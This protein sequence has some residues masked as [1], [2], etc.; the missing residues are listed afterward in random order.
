[1]IKKITKLLLVA[2]IALNLSLATA[3]IT[4]VSADFCSDLEGEF[5]GFLDCEDQFTSFTDFQGGMEAPDSEGFDAS[6]TK[7]KDARTFAKNIANFALGFLG[8]IAVM[9]I[10][11]SGFLYVVAAGD[12]DKMSK[13]KSGITSAMIG[14]VIILS[15]FAIVN[16]IL[17]APS[18]DSTDITTGSLHGAGS[19][20]QATNEQQIQSYNIAA[21]AVADLTKDF[22]ATY[23]K[24]NKQ[25]I[26]LRQLT[27]YKPNEFTSRQDFVDYLQGLK[28]ELNNLKK[29]SGTLSHT[30]LTAQ[31][32]IDLLLN[33]ALQS[34]GET[35]REEDRTERIDSQF[36]GNIENFVEDIASS[37]NDW[38]TR[39]FG[40]LLDGRSYDEVTEGDLFALYECSLPV[41][42]RS[43]N[44]SVENCADITN[45]VSQG[46]LGNKIDAAFDSAINDLVLTKGVYV[47]YDAKLDEYVK[48]LETIKVSLTGNNL[49][50]ESEGNSLV[51]D[52]NSLIAQFES[53]VRASN[54]AT[55]YSESSVS[56]LDD[57]PDITDLAGAL[58]KIKELIIALQKLHNELKTIKFTNPIIDVNTFRGAAPLV[59]KFD[60]S[61]SYNPLNI[62]ATSDM[63]KWDLD[64]NGEFNESRAELLSKGIHCD[65]GSLQDTS[66][67]VNED[68]AKA[69]IT[70][71]F[72]YPGSYT[73]GLQ[74]N[75]F[76]AGSSDQYENQGKVAAGVAYMN[77]QVTPPVSKINLL[78]NIPGK[79]P[80]T[81]R[82]YDDQGRIATDL[83]ALNVALKEIKDTPIE[84]DATETQ[85]NKPLTYNWSF[86]DNN[87]QA[88]G[89][90]HPTA[91]V[92]Y[93][94]RG[95]YEA[96]LTVVDAQENI[97]RKQFIINVQ[98]I[99]A[100]IRAD[101]TT[102]IPGTKIEFN[103]SESVS[104]SGAISSYLWKINGEELEGNNKETFK[105]L[106]DDPGEYNISV[107]V[108]DAE[109]EDTAE[110]T[111]KI[112]SQPPQSVFT[113]SFPKANQPSLVVLNADQSYDPDPNDELTYKWTIY[114]AREGSDYDIIEGSLFEQSTQTGSEQLSLLFYKLGNYKVELSVFDEQAKSS[115]SSQF[116]EISSLVDIKFAEDQIFAS[117]LNEESE[118]NVE[119]TLESEFGNTLIIDFGDG[120]TETARFTSSEATVSHLYKK[121][122]AIEVTAT[123]KKGDDTNAVTETFIIGGGEEPI[124]VP[125]VTINNTTYS[126]LKNLP[127]VYRNDDISFDAS[128]SIST[129]GTN[130]GLAYQWDFG[131]GNDST[132]SV[133]SHH[134]TDLPPA[135]DGF[136]KITL[137][138]EENGKTDSKSFKVKVEEA[139]PEA[140]SLLATALGGA[141]TPTDV[142]LEVIAP[143]DRDG[144]VMKYRYYYFPVN[145]SGR[146]LGM[147]ES[148]D[149]E[150]VLTVETF[151]LPDE[152]IEYGFCVDL[153]DDDGNTTECKDLFEDGKLPTMVAVNG[154]NEPPTAKFTVSD[155][156]INVGET[157]SFTS[158]STDPDGEIIEYIYDF[159]GDGSYVNDEKF[160]N[161]SISHVYEHRSPDEGFQVR[162]K[163]LD[164][165]GATAQ[166]GIIPI[167][168]TG[169]LDE[170]K[171][172]FL[173]E[174]LNDNKVK[175][176]DKS[177]A[178]TEKDGTIVDYAWD[179]N[180]NFDSDGDGETDNDLDSDEKNPTWTY[181]EAGTYVVKLKVKDSE[182]NADEVTHTIK[183]GSSHGSADTDTDNNDNESNSE[184]ENPVN[185]NNSDVKREINLIYSNPPLNKDAHE[186]YLVG[187]EGRVN[188]TFNKI[189]LDID[190]IYV[191][192]YIFFDS[193]GDGTRYNDI[194]FST[195][196]TRMIYESPIFR[197]TAPENNALGIAV[198]VIDTNGEIYF[199]F[200]KVV[201]VGNSLQ[202]A[203]KLDIANNIGIALYVLL[204][205]IGLSY[206][207]SLLRHKNNDKKLL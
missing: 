199:D 90:S 152:E 179:F 63:Y 114:N 127:V 163:V 200:A 81:L 110:I 198:T 155:T 107:T 126:D 1:M 91:K 132:S 166:S 106:F 40:G 144:R 86:E 194:D 68:A 104:D 102:G 43:I 100:R 187:E 36:E 192:S 3:S 203:L 135:N 153:T 16:T 30:A 79:D 201:F 77:M 13:G 112:E 5:A 20:S 76:P 57:A 165:K 34:I 52:L 87:T 167:I 78:A 26:R 27:S 145:D 46:D 185:L 108:K 169:V 160:E 175:F 72:Q 134:Y 9:I 101:K 196:D 171:A 38:W 193:D 182:G 2:I 25:Q 181:E 45:N 59:V 161:G 75:P 66:E 143:I 177:K 118:A 180:T 164:D 115:I 148:N 51:T 183:L 131:D 149:P 49:S 156:L 147:K 103:A 24:F 121:A 31:A 74:L 89:S 7:A 190:K 173:S 206:G 15:S 113:S 141:T 64:G 10:I 195:T 12:E 58:D 197:P 73:V 62:T 50:S 172:A 159:E 170:P 97:D 99:V 136:F 157:I 186:I 130:A 69:T 47:D 17:Q 98:D 125:M 128:K 54:I 70:C 28:D 32:T 142:K 6:L 158:E 168:V 42:E 207:A 189:D 174:I 129:D 18:G 14:I 65:D 22:I 67:T 95:T 83:N 202:A 117:Q 71:T 178:D 150:A 122:G 119:F 137:E 85:G 140:K 48:R 124:A 88:S 39:N 29:Q 191:D 120:K 146:M 205:G 61:R 37:A 204:L 96:M 123:A 80:L 105:H 109:N 184:S 8:L 92:Q 53:E 94:E 139:V 21:A 44:S 82:A 33:P 60:T 151:G 154:P 176:T 23:E 56:F 111:V 93:S 55:E 162:L 138:V 188:L 116:I 19:S 84:F 41:S 11:Y 4:T 133:T 35:I